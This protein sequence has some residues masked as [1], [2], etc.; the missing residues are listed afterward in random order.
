MNNKYIDGMNEIKADEVFKRKIINN[1]DQDNFQNNMRAFTFKP[2]VITMLAIC[3]FTLVTFI[4]NPFFQSNNTAKQGKKQN[5]ALSLFNGFEITTYANTETPVEIKPN[6]EFVIGRYN[7]IMSNVPGF[8][9]RIT[10]DK[11]EI[12]KLTVTDGEFLLWA[13]PI[14]TN[15]GSTLEIKSGETIYW[16]PISGK[17]NSSIPNCTLTIEAYKNDSKLGSNIINI[18]SD[19]NGNYSAIVSK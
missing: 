11:A 3:A 15:K 2:I 1:I 5:A 8:P 14:V 10:C 18:K 13:N 12:I 19:S 6:V 16:T 7:P 4:G 9:L 17:S